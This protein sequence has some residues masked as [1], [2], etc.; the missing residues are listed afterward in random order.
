MRSEV[1]NVVDRLTL[2]TWAND[3]HV[4][5]VVETPR[6][7]REGRPGS[8]KTWSLRSALPSILCSTSEAQLK[9]IQDLPSRAREEME[10]FFRAPNALENEALKFL[11]WRGPAQAGK[12]I[13]CS[14]T[15]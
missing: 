3:E 2:P 11:A 1:H 15:K 6:G 14:A 4:F 5:A 7:S 9:D 13:R 8:A 12:T 10:G